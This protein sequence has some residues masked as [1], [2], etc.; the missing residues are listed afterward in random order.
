MICNTEILVSLV[1]T[2]FNS[3]EHIGKT[4]DSIFEQD[5]PHIE[6]VV[7]DGGSTDATEKIVR[8]YMKGR[9]YPIIFESRQDTGIYDAMNQGYAM[10]HGD[11]IAFFNDRFLRRDAISMMVSS[12]DKEHADGAHADLVYMDG[13]KVV[14]YWHMGTGKIRQGWMPG[15]PTL[16]LK[17]D[18]YEKYG[19]Y[20]TDYKISADYEF[21]VRVLKDDRVRLAYVPSI[22]I[23]MYYGGTSSAGL[24][25][26]WLSLK[27]A[28]RGLRENGVSFPVFISLKRTLKLLG[29]F[30]RANN[31]KI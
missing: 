29:Q 31:T 28:I 26:Y 30:L 15:H 6:I 23:G 4:L 17:R 14:R 13:D 2:T 1:L 20:K 21:M 27:E 24:G 8:E 12:I 22:I 10:A 18:I 19:L 7:K 3:E 9:R 16:F 11:V 25:S 5:Y